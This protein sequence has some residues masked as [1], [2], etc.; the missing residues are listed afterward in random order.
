MPPSLDVGQPGPVVAGGSASGTMGGEV[1]GEPERARDG[2]GGGARWWGAGQEQNVHGR[3]EE[4]KR[5]VTVRWQF[6]YNMGFGG[7]AKPEKNDG[8]KKTITTNSL[9]IVKIKR[10][11]TL[12]ELCSTLFIIV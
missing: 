7:R 6:V 1:E 9:I 4:K 8:R 12:S 3:E 5:T 11:Q 10:K 2:R